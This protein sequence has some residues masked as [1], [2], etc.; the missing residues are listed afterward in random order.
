M[1]SNITDRFN[2]MNSKQKTECEQKINFENE[3]NENIIPKKKNPTELTIGNENTV[4]NISTVETL[5]CLQEFDEILDNVCKQNEPIDVN[6][7]YDIEI[8]IEGANL[9]NDLNTLGDIDNF[10][11]WQSIFDDYAKNTEAITEQHINNNK[12]GRNGNDSDIYMDDNEHFNVNNHLDTWKGIYEDFANKINNIAPVTGKNMENTDV[13]YNKSVLDELSVI[14]HDNSYCLNNETRIG[15]T[16]NSSAISKPKQTEKYNPTDSFKMFNIQHENVM[17]NFIEDQKKE[18]NVQQIRAN[19][20][21]NNFTNN[22]LNTEGDTDELNSKRKNTNTFKKEY[23]EKHV[24]ML[25]QSNNKRADI[26]NMCN[27]IK[28]HSAVDRVL[29]KIIKNETIVLISDNEDPLEIVECNILINKTPTDTNFA[30][31]EL[32]F[33]NNEYLNVLANEKLNSEK[34]VNQ[35]LETNNPR[36]EFR[37]PELETKCLINNKISANTNEYGKQDVECNMYHIEVSSTKE[38]INTNELAKLESESNSSEYLYNHKQ[39]TNKNEFETEEVDFDC[40]GYNSS[41]FEFI[42]EDTGKNN[43]PNFELLFDEFNNYLEATTKNEPNANNGL[44]FEV[45]NE[46]TLPNIETLFAIHD[47]QKPINFNDFC[48]END[49]IYDYIKSI[50]PPANANEVESYKDSHRIPN[51]DEFLSLFGGNFTPYPMY[52]F[53][54]KATNVTSMSLDIGEVGIDM[55]MFKV[56]STPEERRKAKETEQKILSMYSIENRNYKRRR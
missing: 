29:N 51:E 20:F 7:K 26:N 37:N 43:A 22:G 31:Q 30:K 19:P 17:L 6:T 53:E 25:E 4:S 46:M 55:N 8:D 13:K 39:P 24:D 33:N 18:S 54:N 27:T 1:M 16:P 49:I 47:N 23:W 40:D 56:E 42:D 32:K 28:H 14:K 48:E 35:E 5:T 52:G 12:E 44:N 41:D 2:S 38:P 21:N 36:N 15:W 11:N 10:G 45:F 3:I 50:Q 9:E 34:L